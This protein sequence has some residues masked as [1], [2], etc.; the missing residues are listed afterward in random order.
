MRVTS[1]VVVVRV[2]D[3][4]GG[5]VVGG[6]VVSSSGGVDVGGSS[7][8]VGGSSVGVGGVVVPGSVGEEEEA[9]DVVRVV[10]R[11]VEDDEE[12][13]EAVLDGVG[14]DDVES[15]GGV[16]GVDELAPRVHEPRPLDLVCPK[17]V[18]PGEGAV[19]PERRPAY[20]SHAGHSAPTQ[21]RVRSSSYD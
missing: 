6:V 16:V 5:V 7:V 8:D 12:E 15:P 9:L 1:V 2:V 3:V 17:P 20:V 19:A 18:H 11:D 14:V 10:G 13:E 4:P 21:P